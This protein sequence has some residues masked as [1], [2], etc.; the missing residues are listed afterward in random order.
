MSWNV[1]EN[2]HESRL[3]MATKPTDPMFG[4]QNKGKGRLLGKEEKFN[5]CVR[6]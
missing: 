1:M 5:F 4:I 6:A 3:Q 2:E